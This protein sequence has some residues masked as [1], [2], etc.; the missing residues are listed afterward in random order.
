MEAAVFQGHHNF[1]ERVVM[2]TLHGRPIKITK[3]RSTDLNPGL[4]DHEVSFLRL[5]EAVTNGLKIEIS[6]TGTTV[7][8]HPGIIVG[9]QLK[10]QCPSG[11]TVGYYVEGMLYLAPFSKN[12]FSIVFT[13]ISNSSLGP[14][15]DAIK[16]G[17]L[18]MLEKFGVRDIAIHILKRGLA[19]QGGA[20]VH[21]ICN[22]LLKLPLTLHITEP[23]KF[24]AIRGVAYST[25]VLPLTVNRMIDTA[26]AALRPTGVDVNITADVWRGEH[27]GLLP[28]WGMTLVAELKKGW[29]LTLENVGT[30]GLLPEDLGEKLA[31]ELLYRLQH[32]AVVA[33]DQVPLTFVYMCLGSADIGRLVLNRDQ[34]DERLVLLLRDIKE[35]FDIEVVFKDEGDTL[36][37]M[38]K[39]RGEISA[40][41]KIQGF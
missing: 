26:R 12:K 21:L 3:I 40:A 35:V 5:I 24:L 22:T 13:G 7:I 41:K 32:N 17:M 38:V 27:A 28:G 2:A 34:V 30:A 39:G 19:P 16:W 20:E 15:I 23:P 10:H 1:R 18:P 11:T 9:G 4:R 31:L 6:Y 25:R 36:V 29:R 8:Y 37:A 33:G 14:G